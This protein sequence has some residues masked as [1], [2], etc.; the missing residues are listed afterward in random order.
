MINSPENFKLIKESMKVDD[1][2]YNL[3]HKIVTY[4]YEELEKEDNN[5]SSI[6]DRIEDEEVQN[7]LTAIMA[8]DYGITD[9]KKA[10]ED[11]LKKYEKEK[12]ENRRDE[13]IKE[14]SLEQDVEKKRKI[15]EELNNIILKLAKLR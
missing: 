9:N 8:E 1:F 10:V 14:T 12:L 11:I 13:L 6:L 2:K 3:N 4:L 7:H 5:I 15:G